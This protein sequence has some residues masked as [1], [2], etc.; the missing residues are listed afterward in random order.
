MS[1]PDDPEPAARGRERLKERLERRGLAPPAAIVGPAFSFD[2]GQAI[3]AVSLKEATAAAALRFMSGEG[4]AVGGGPAAALAG[5]V[6]C[7]MFFGQMNAVARL[8]L[9]LG[10]IGA[11]GWLA[12]P[13]AATP[14]PRVSAP[15]SRSRAASGPS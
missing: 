1:C 12:R 2:R 10:L 7:A 4:T 6:L 3:V 9:L 15:G 8:A 5:E 11:G 13:S 14:R